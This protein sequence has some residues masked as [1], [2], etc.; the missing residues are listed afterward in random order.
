MIIN[1]EINI[2]KNCYLNLKFV[3]ISCN[4]VRIIIPHVPRALQ[5]TISQW[6]CSGIFNEGTE[7]LR[8][9]EKPPGR[10]GV[11]TANQIT[12][13]DQWSD[14]K[15]MSVNTQMANRRGALGL[16]KLFP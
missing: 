13:Q 1:P 7:T 11:K 15:K 10:E 4:V 5:Q 2:R 9:L 3:F 8:T 16:I 14:Y 6:I 12:E